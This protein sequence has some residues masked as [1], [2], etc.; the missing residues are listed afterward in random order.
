M[1]E[2]WTLWLLVHWFAPSHQHG[3][4]F[5]NGSISREVA[6]SSR[7]SIPKMVEALKLMDRLQTRDKVHPSELDL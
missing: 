2:N 5:L 1:S 3:F 4:S 6:H 7:F